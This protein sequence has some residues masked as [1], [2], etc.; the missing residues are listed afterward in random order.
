MRV[1]CGRSVIAGG[2]HVKTVHRHSKGRVVHFH[3][4]NMSRRGTMVAP[5]H[6]FIDGVR[7]TLKVRFD[8]AVPPVADPAGY[9]QS[10]GLALTTDP[11]AHALHVAG[12]HHPDAFI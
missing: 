5:T 11:K 9:A 10:F 3:P 1:T 7:R 2:A 6:Q 8:A 4:E 12:N